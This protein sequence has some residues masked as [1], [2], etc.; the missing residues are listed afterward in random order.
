LVITN[1]MLVFNVTQ[2][3]I[4]NARTILWEFHSQPLNKK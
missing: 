3:Q 1:A 4:M 2:F